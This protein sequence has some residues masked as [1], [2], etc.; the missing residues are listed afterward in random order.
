MPVCSHEAPATTHSGTALHPVEL[1]LNLHTGCKLPLPLPLT[2]SIPSPKAASRNRSI[3]PSKPSTTPCFH[4]HMSP[5]SHLPTFPHPLKVP[6]GRSPQLPSRTEGPR[7]SPLNIHNTVTTFLPL[8]NQPHPVLRQLHVT[9]VRINRTQN[10]QNQPHHTSPS[11]L[12]FKPSS[13]TLA[14]LS[15][16]QSQDSTSAFLTSRFRVVPHISFA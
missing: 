4:T 10:S 16:P 7:N 11:S 5:P 6:H 12:A 15:H 2:Y 14:E 1:Q 9:V 8:S 3:F 13:S